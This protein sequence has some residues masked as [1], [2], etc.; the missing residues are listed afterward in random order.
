MLEVIEKIGNM[1]GHTD[2]NIMLMEN[3]EFGGSYDRPWVFSTVRYLNARGVTV[4]H[5]R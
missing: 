5:G 4:Q 3:D 1:Y 2:L